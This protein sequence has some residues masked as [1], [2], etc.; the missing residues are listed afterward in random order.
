MPQ[1][2]VFIYVALTQ[3]AESL[4]VAKAY[5]DVPERVWPIA[6]RSLLAHLQR[7]ESI[8]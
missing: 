2:N 8:T 4:R 7:L 1:I 5:D 3:V 6:K